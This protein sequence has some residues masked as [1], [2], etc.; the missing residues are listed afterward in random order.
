MI[1]EQNK[2]LALLLSDLTLVATDALFVTAPT[3]N[4]TCIASIWF[5]NVGYTLELVPLL[6]E[7]AAIDQIVSA[8]AQLKRVTL[9]CANL[10]RVVVFLV[11]VVVLVWTIFDPPRKGTSL[12][13]SDEISDHGEYIVW[14]SYSCETRSRAGEFWSVAWHGLWLLCATV[15]AFQHDIYPTI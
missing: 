6:V 12:K 5:K 9:N 3:S 13:V 15:L 7:I 10:F 1:L 4:V 11:V 2:F 14:Q 8:A